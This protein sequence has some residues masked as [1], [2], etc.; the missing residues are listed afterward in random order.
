MARE[1]P[2]KQ[3]I[4]DF[5]EEFRTLGRPRVDFEPRPEYF[6]FLASKNLIEYQANKVILDDLNYSHYALGPET[7][8]NPEKYPGPVWKFKIDKFNTIV[9]IKL[10]IYPGKFGE[11]S[12]KCLSFHNDRNKF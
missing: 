8:Y 9:Y 11:Q 3:E 4:E 1:K 12:A 2:A 6:Q 10:K 7:D 5:L